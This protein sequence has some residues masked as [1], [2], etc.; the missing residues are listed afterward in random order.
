MRQNAIVALLVLCAFLLAANL[1]LQLTTTTRLP[2]AF[3]QAPAGNVLIAAANTQNEAFCFLYNA[4]TKQLASIAESPTRAISMLMRSLGEAQARAE[5]A[6]ARW[7]AVRSFVGQHIPET[8]PRRAMFDEMSRAFEAGAT[9]DGP[10]R[11]H[12]DHDD[13]DEGVKR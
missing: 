6:E 11:K 8:D 12:E 10:A 3:S 2:L 9:A 5:A 13:H 4:E 7:R 1:T